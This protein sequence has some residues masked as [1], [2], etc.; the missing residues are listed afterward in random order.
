MFR[1]QQSP[2]RPKIMWFGSLDYTTVLIA[3]A[4]LFAPLWVVLRL[5]RFLRAR[6]P[7]K[8]NPKLAKYGS[9]EDHAQHRSI[10]ASKIVATSSTDRIVGYHIQQQVE[11]VYVDGFRRPE[12]ALEG[13]KASA[14]MKGANALSN[15]RTERTS[16]GKCAAHGDA[17]IVKRVNDE[18]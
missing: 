5:R 14:A 12:E 18:G 4:A 7:A 2:P 10:E 17:V 13:L 6:R 3:A 16:A 11:A 15:V 8:L 1:P 9:P